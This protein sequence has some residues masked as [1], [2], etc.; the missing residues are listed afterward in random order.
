MATFKLFLMIVFVAT[1]SSLTADAQTVTL[2]RAVTGRRDPIALP[3]PYDLLHPP[4]AGIPLASAENFSILAKTGITNTPPSNIHGNIGVSSTSGSGMT[5]FDFTPD[6]SL[7]FMT[8]VDVHGMAFASDYNDPTP[9]T[10]A[11][12]IADMENA[13]SNAAL[14]P[15]A[16]GANLN[17]GGGFIS[18]STFTPGIHTWSS[19]VNISENIYIKGNRDSVYIFH[20]SGNLTLTNGVKML[21]TADTQNGSHPVP[22]NVFWLVNGAVLV[23][24][25]SLLHGIFLVTG[26][27][28]MLAGSVLKGRIF[29]LGSCSLDNV[30]VKPPR[31]SKKSVDAMALP[32]RRNA[33]HF[34]R[35]K[36]HIRPH[37]ENHKHK[38]DVY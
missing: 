18:G 32:T 6:A 31:H 3:T 13:F 26:D 30:T 27:V 38:E 21:F 2:R 23:G 19:D 7:S 34:R 12:A 28:L 16:R 37:Y 29:S 36:M 35:N 1:L 20:I 15:I 14:R 5:G 17:R 10:M 25:G 11:T 22:T 9:A 24:K 4:L 8:S 33:T